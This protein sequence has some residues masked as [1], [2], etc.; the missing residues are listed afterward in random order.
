M[1]LNKESQALR[2]NV[3]WQPPTTPQ[4]YLQKKDRGEQSKITQ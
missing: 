4:G 2:T 3:L 1:K